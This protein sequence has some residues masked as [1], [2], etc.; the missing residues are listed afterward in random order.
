MKNKLIKT[1]Y[2]YTLL[3]LFFLSP[4]IAL[5]ETDPNGTTGLGSA[6]ENV[7]SFAK[8]SGYN[9]DNENGE[10]L[11]SNFLA[12]VINLVFSILGLLF[13]ILTIIAGYKWMTAAGNQDHVTK[14]KK[15]LKENIIGLL[16]VVLSWGIWAL[17]LQIFN[18]L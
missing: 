17:I 9:I 3:F 12:R 18:Q 15:A 14:A 13:V 4:Q 11:I 7:N 5:L 16:I 6:F 1:K 8:D 2:L 10:T